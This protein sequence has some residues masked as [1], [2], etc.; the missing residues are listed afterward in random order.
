M[1]YT[2]NDEVINEIREASDIVDIISD[3]IELK[4]TGLNYKGICPFHNEK[5]PSFV[6]SPNKQIFHCFGCGEGGDIITFLMKHRNLTFIEALKDLADRSNIILPEGNDDAGKKKYDEREKLFKLNR[7]AALFYYNNLKSNKRALKYLKSRNIDFKIINKFGIGYA[8]DSWDDLFKYL[9]EKGYE[10]EL[11]YKVG[12]IVQRRDKSGYYNRFRN[13]IIFPIINIRGKVLGFGGRV[14]DDGQ[15][16]YLNTPDTPIFNKGYNLYGIN[17]IKDNRRYDKAILVEGYMDVI[18]LNKYGVDYA[19]ASLGTAFTENQAKL[20]KRYAK[21][22][23]ICYDSDEAGMRATDKALEVL[24][25]Q[26]IKAKVIILPKGKD[27]DDFIKERG[28]KAYQEAIN[29]SLDLID[30]KIYM[31]KKKFD[32]NKPEGKIKF[33]KKITQFLKKMKGSIEFDVYINEISN[34]TGISVDTIK[35]EIYGYRDNNLNKSYKDKYSKPYFRNNIKDRIKPVE[36]SLEPGHLTAEKRLLNLLLQDKNIYNKVKEEF[37]YM[38]FLDE[39]N[40]KIAEIIYKKYEKSE[41]LNIEEII[42]ELDINTSEK[43]RN[44]INLVSNDDNKE[45]AIKDYVNRIN[46]YKK[47]IRRDY[48]KKEINQ[49]KD[50]TD[51]SKGEVE[52]LRVL[53]MEYV[54]LDKELKV[55][56]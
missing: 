10:E 25:Q 12:L 2:Y 52:K 45:K 48:L 30:Y 55:N 27:P 40:R 7:E 19:V 1:S 51:K 34:N 37:M 42:D 24:Y 29:K 56:H 22:F 33:T 36:F 9:K 18:S 6:V 13:R 17:I 16:K 35:N 14:I 41:V 23:Y 3:Y 39:D 49:I 38:D 20:L 32:I 31:Y 26:G 15:P 54:Q 46:Y 53:M 50:K 8:N 43:L 28:K 47:K 4:K 21:E 5:T 11:I 44:I